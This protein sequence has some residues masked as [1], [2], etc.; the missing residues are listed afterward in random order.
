MSTINKTSK[1]INTI[2]KSRNILLK[3]FKHRNYDVSEYE[4]ASISDIYSI[5]RTDQMNMLLTHDT[6]KT[7]V[8]YH[9]YKMLRASNIF[10]LVEELFDYKEIL[11]KDTD[12]LL[13]IVK[14]EPNDT[15]LKIITQLW[16]ERGIYVNVV[17]IQR[18]LFNI[19]EHEVVPEHKVLTNVE[20]EQILKRYNIKNSSKQLP[21]ISR[22]DPV[23][24]AI[25]LRPGQVCEIIRPSPL[26]IT[27]KYYRVCV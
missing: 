19:L 10:D 2:F 17:N 27:T 24:V 22:F 16:K 14:S 18:L 7:Y 3:Q 13:I 6:E 21:T 15:I 12:T 4:N 25:G 1:V 26:T 23:A 5:V 20:T 8:H 9:I 11:D